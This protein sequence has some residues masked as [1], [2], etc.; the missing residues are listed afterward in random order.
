M[1]Y[2]EGGGGAAIQTPNLYHVH[3]SHTPAAEAKMP[4]RFDLRV[5]HKSRVHS[6][7]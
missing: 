4:M 7:S 1:F 5:F 6:R 3:P 2:F